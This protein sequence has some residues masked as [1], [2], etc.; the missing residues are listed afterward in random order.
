MGDSEE[1]VSPSSKR[2]AKKKYFPFGTPSHLN[3]AFSQFSHLNTETKG[4]A[5][6]LAT[7]TDVE[8]EV[9]EVKPQRRV[10]KRPP[11]PSMSSALGSK[12]ADELDPV[13]DGIP[14]AE[15][16]EPCKQ[17]PC[18]Q[19]VK[20]IIDLQYQNE[21]ERDE[22]EEEYQRLLLELEVAQ[23]RIVTEE[24]KLVQLNEIGN[25]LEQRH[26]KLIGNVETLEATR[27]ALH[28]ER[29]D[30]NNKVRP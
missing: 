15:G 2:V 29:S 16:M 9:I 8:A 4:F 26:N 13:N 24:E 1:E 21:V 11:K 5:I 20:A 23:K 27:E 18:Q 10:V 14:D 22:I 28:T 7:A 3:H 19:V 17:L 6:G 12:S 30:I 25:Q